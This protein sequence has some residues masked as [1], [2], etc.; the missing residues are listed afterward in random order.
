MGTV[1]P[2][3]STGPITHEV[4]ELVRGGQILEAR[5]GGKVGVA[6][7]GSFRVVGVAS[8]DAAPAGTI[9]DTSNT[10][11][12]YPALDLSTGLVTPY[13]ATW[14]NEHVSVVYSAAAA[15]GDALVAAANGQVAPAGVAPDAR[16][17]IGWCSE[18]DGVTAAGQ[19]G[20][21][22]ISR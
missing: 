15:F 18:P 6:A 20:L 5:A 1:V 2:K 4:V 3:F 21:A 14:E 8:K 13:V 17:I 19:V 10:S 11:S 12:G 22:R 16:S 7:A 9:S